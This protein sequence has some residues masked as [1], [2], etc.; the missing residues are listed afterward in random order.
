MKTTLA[1]LVALVSSSAFASTTE[2]ELG[3]FI[4]YQDRIELQ[5]SSLA[6]NESHQAN[7][8]MY[9]QRVFK[10]HTNANLV[11][12]TLARADGLVLTSNGKFNQALAD[13]A[14]KHGS[15]FD[16]AYKTLMV[17]I[18]EEALGEIDMSQALTNTPIGAFA[19]VIRTRVAQ[20]LQDAQSL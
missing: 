7:I 4:N 3:S 19:Q 5:A 9:A 8:V 1:I 13:L 2:V 10:N 15:A 20:G 17:C 18:H 14:M 16:Q 11:L 12:T 6:L